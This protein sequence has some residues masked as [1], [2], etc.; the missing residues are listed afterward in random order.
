MPI[1]AY[2]QKNLKAGKIVV[3]PIAKAT[4]SVK[5]VM[6]IATPACWKKENKYVLK[7][8]GYRGRHIITHSNLIS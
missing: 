2:R 6:V 7:D 1:E 5:E 3:P 4:M 8:P